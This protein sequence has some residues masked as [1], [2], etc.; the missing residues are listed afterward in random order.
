MRQFRRRLQWIGAT[1][2]PWGL[3][4]GL[5]VSFTAAAGHNPALTASLSALSSV[6]PHRLAA[7]SAV[8]LLDGRVRV[9]S[10]GGSAITLEDTSYL[11]I[12]RS[13]RI[14]SNELTPRPD[15]KAV[16]AV[17]PDVDR[18]LKGDPITNSAG[19]RRSLSRAVSPNR[20]VALAGLT[21]ELDERDL[22]VSAFTPAS[23]LSLFDTESVTVFEP[24]ETLMASQ[25]TSMA[26]SDQSPEA[27]ESTPTAAVGPEMS[28]AT[29]AVPRALVLASA[30]PAAADA[31]PLA[32]A[33]VP[34]SPK[35]AAAAQGSLIAKAD[36]LKP[37]P[38]KLVRSRF[39]GIVTPANIQRELKCLAEAVYFEARSEPESGQAAVAQVVLNRAMSGLY[40][41]S[42]C[43]VVYQNRHRYL[44]CQ[45]T[46]ACE[47][48]SLRITE[49]DHWRVATRVA[50]AV[51]D[52]KTYL[53]GVGSATHYHATY[54]RPYWAKRLRRMDKIGQ[55]VF[56]KLRPGQT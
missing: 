31:T 18:T 41:S 44:A 54:V 32:I 36:P 22:T 14:L 29:P 21:F 10:L 15:L 47:G 37:D 43:G 45:F 52:G 49:P 42:V 23:N 38:S 53:D 11:A 56:Y 26:N 50:R 35:A 17:Y 28:G 2:A 46:F 34:V 8:P 40:P 7:A 5:L 24:R 12:V 9:A 25:L 4:G 27:A 30:T 55:H 16:A 20:D 13:T 1:F 39:A 19:L 48:K 33:A 3:A 6:L 51:F